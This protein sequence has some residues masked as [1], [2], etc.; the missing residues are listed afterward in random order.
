MSGGVQIQ[1]ARG[2]LIASHRDRPTGFSGF[3]SF[4]QHLAAHSHRALAS[5]VEINLSVFDGNGI[6][7]HQSGGVDDLAGYQI[8]GAGGDQH[9]A[10]VGDDVAAVGDQR[11]GCRITNLVLQQA[12]AVQFGGEAFRGTQRR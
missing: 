4:G 3:L 10:A 9:F 6:G 12:I 2:D 5:A 11:R 8:G 1:S 7:F